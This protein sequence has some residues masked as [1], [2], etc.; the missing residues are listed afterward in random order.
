[1]NSLN[2]SEDSSASKFYKDQA[3]GYLFPVLKALTEVRDET[4]SEF[5]LL[6]NVECFSD[7]N[8]ME[9]LCLKE[10]ISPLTK[11]Q[12]NEVIEKLKT[13]DG[14]RNCFIYN[15]FKCCD[16]FRPWELTNRR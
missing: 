3:E 5:T 9:V 16:S 15:S 8:K 12:L 4:G 2:L 14:K 10:E 7:I 1:M 11:F 6:E 13:K